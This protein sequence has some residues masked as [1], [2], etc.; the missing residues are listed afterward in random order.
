MMRTVLLGGVALVLGLGGAASAQDLVVTNARILDGAGGVID[1]GTVVVDDGVITSVGAGA[2]TLD[3]ATV[4]DAEGRTVMPGFIDAH[5]HLGGGAPDWLD[6]AAPAAMQGWLD[7]GFTTILDALAIGP[8]AEQYAELRRRIDAG[9]I[10]GPR[11]KLSGMVPVN[12]T[13]MP[14]GV[15]DAA[16]ADPARIP[17]DERAPVD[18]TPPDVARGMVDGYAAQGL[19]NIK[20]ILV[21]SPKGDDLA[22]LQAIA[23]QAHMHDMRMIIHTTAVV[24]ALVAAEGGVDYYAHTPHIGWVD[25][26]DT[27]ERIVATGAPMVSTLGVFTPY[28]G[29]EGDGLFRDFGHFPYDGTLHSAGQGPVNL[30]LLAEAGVTACY[31]TDTSFSPRESLRHEISALVSVFSP[32][33][34]VKMLTGNAAVCTADEEVTGTLTVGKQGDLVI[35]DGDPLTDIFAVMDVRLVAKGGVIVSDQR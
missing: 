19:D 26:G 16:R 30:R 6:T 20:L 25:E 8:S 17:F 22:T 9:E 14:Q 33:D 4:I 32:A 18:A 15:S 7:A 1:N 2:A 29:P 23:D 35:V 12:Q 24:D 34:I 5:R 3:G 10:P 28:Y 27:I 13:A 21:A 31:G 11:L